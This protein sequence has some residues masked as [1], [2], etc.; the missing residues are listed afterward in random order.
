M[1]PK[2]SG[3]FR[4]RMLLVRLFAGVI[5]LA[6]PFGSFAYTI[7]NSGKAKA[8]NTI[9]VSPVKF[10]LTLAPGGSATKEVTIWN[11]LGHE[12]EF[13]FSKEDF[14]GSKDPDKAT[15]FLGDDYAKITS[16]KDWLALETDKVTLNQG[17]KMKFPVQVNVPA[18]ASPGSHY[19]A[20]FS[21][22]GNSADATGERAV[23]LRSR[24]GCLFLINVTGKTN[25][26]GAVTEFMTDKKFYRN[27]PVEFSTV[28]E[29]T[30]NVYQNVNADISV[31]NIFGNESSHLAIKNWTVLSDSSR[32]Q[33][34]TWPRKWMVGIYTAELTATFGW[35]G[36]M[37]D[38]KQ[39]VF[40]V[41]PWHAALAVLIGLILLYYLLKL[42]FS[43]VEIRRRRR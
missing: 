17:D 24:V 37:T 42:L 22:V 10:E 19:A 21:T 39:I 36:D 29:N 4:G 33:K 32:R 13:L 40:Y 7:Q 30:G 18:D 16:A 9:T 34:I 14:T 31:R 15:L 35:K 43:K 1:H 8:L 25:E 5:L 12:S 3:Y 6:Q 20:V 41:F 27:G 23:N 28:F 26:A 11:R 2:I 38:H